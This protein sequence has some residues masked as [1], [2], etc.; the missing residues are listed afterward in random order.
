M[1]LISISGGL[2]MFLT[3]KPD[4][5]CHQIAGWPVHI[6]HVRVVTVRVEVAEVVSNL[7]RC[8]LVH[9][10]LKDWVRGS[11]QVVLGLHKVEQGSV[12]WGLVPQDIFQVALKWTFQTLKYL[13]PIE[14]PL[15][16]G[17]FI[18]LNI[19]MVTLVF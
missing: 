1:F 13:H 3:A 19:G 7:P 17:C 10:Q 8:S 6:A 9:G 18:N 5:G 11:W 4:A 16:L 12:I 15:V 2:D 14:L